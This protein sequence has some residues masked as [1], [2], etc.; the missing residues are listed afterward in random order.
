MNG[1]VVCGCSKQGVGGGEGQILR[2]LYIALGAVPK[3]VMREA[4]IPK[5]RT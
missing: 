1:L 2:L 5:A 4:S 3:R